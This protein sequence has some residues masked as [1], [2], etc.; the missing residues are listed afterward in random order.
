MPQKTDAELTA[1]ANVIGDET[2][3]FANTADR[4]RDHL[5][6]IIDSKVN[7]DE[8]GSGHV[9]EDEGTPLTQRTKLNFVGAGVTVTD[10]SGDDASVVTIDFSNRMLG[11]AFSDEITPITAAT[12]KIAFHFPYT[13]TIQEI[14]IELRTVQAS[15]NIFTVDVHK[16][17][18]TILSTKLTIDNGEETSL[19]AATP[20]VISVS[21]VTKGDRI[22]IDVDQV[23]NGT[24]IGGKI[25][26]RG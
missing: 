6:D 14:W 3:Q 19:T 23:G 7:N 5:I 18:T 13:T 9:I 11:V 22:T 8:A 10:D 2:T 16:N 26:F 15:G 12:D 24:A 21:S 17:G 4:V 20:P 1:D 25:W